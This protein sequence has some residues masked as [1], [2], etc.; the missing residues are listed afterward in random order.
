LEQPIARA[1]AVR[2]A[3]TSWVEEDS[4]AASTYVNGLAEPEIRDHAILGLIDGIWIT[5]PQDSTTWAQ[6]MTDAELRT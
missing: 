6:S 4:V 5:N 3:V 1:Y 2:A